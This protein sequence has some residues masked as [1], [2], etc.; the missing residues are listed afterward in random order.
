M[1][2]FWNTTATSGPTTWDVLKF[3]DRTPRPLRLLPRSRPAPFGSWL[4]PEILTSTEAFE[5]VHYLRR[6]YNAGPEGDWFLDPSEDWIAAILDERDTIALV[7]R[8]EI[9]MS[10]QR[11]M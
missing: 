8:N 3:W 9:A 7:V 1:S 10:F 4:A 2:Q 5:F 6:Y 11:P